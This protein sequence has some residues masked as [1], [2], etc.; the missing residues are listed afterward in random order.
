MSRLTISRQPKVPALQ[1][2]SLPLKGAEVKFAR[3]PSEAAHRAPARTFQRVPMCAGCCKPV[4]GNFSG[5]D[6]TD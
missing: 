1:N 2:S 3:R 6:R 5:D 4:L